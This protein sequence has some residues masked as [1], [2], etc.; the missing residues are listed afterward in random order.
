MSCFNYICIDLKSFY[1]SVE[2]VERGLDPFKT[3]LVVA[4]P[5]RGEGTI[6]LAVSPA[7]KALGVGG[8]CRVYEIPEGIDYIKA[9]PRMQKYID[10]SA[11]IYEIYLRYVSKDDIHVYSV[12]EAFFDIAPYLT[13]Y[14]M[15]ERS[16]ACTLRDAVFRET[17]I[18]AA[19]GMGTNLY[20]AKVALDILAKHSPGLI[21]MLDEELYK[22]RLW[23]HKPLTDFWRIGRGISRR[24]ARHGMLTMRHIALADKDMLY[25]LLGID[26]ELLI[27]HAWGIETTTME[28]IKRYRPKQKSLSSGQVLFRD[29]SYDEA[30]LILKEML[31]GLCLEMTSEHLITDTVTFCIMYTR[32]A[33]IPYSSATVSLP[34]R[35]ASHRT[36]I[37]AAVKA[38]DRVVN[39]KAAIRRLS[40]DFRDITPDS[41]DRQIT[42]FDIARNDIHARDI[43]MQEAVLRIKA[44]F[45]RNAVF[46]GID[47]ED[48]ATALERNRQIGGHCK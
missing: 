35:T 36:I 37:A 14:D 20:L 12:D 9:R 25:R 30:R 43:R 24:L 7:L 46:K 16:I 32:T 29:Y 8:R 42:M 27:D 13:L 11:R 5:D 6:C 48:C 34:S 38:Y 44:R 4:D 1:A 3:K 45:G 26:A 47:L 40:V 41:S 18:P 17:G 2:C 28:D 22:K 33:D 31:E 23:D 15:D 10:Y 19:C 21:S 39:K